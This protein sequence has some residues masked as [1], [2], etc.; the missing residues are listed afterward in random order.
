[1]GTDQK[2]STVSILSTFEAQVVADWHV[3]GDG[4]ALY[5]T[6]DGCG[7]LAHC[8][9]KKRSHMLCI[10]CFDQGGKQ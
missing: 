5:T 3:W 1:V 7:S 10:V 9:G 2:E 6:C 8:R 4:Y